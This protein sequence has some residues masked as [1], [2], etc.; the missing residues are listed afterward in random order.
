MVNFRRTLKSGPP[1]PEDP[2]DA[3]TLEW[4][5]SS[6]PPHYN[7][8]DIPVVHSLDDYW[9]RKYQEDDEGRP[10]RVVSGAANGESHGEAP[11]A[12]ADH[13]GEAGGHPGHHEGHGIHMPSPSYMPALTALGF[14]LVGF[15]AIYGWPLLAAGGV[16]ILAGLFGWG[17]EPLVEEE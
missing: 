11:A 14:P 7:F 13:G 16:V 6:P 17:H 10:V 8:A 9:H 4:S 12:V 3:R 1:A 2:W 5:I 15:G